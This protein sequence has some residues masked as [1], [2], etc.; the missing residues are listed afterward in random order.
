MEYLVERSSMTRA[1]GVGEPVEGEVGATDRNQ[2][3]EEPECPDKEFQGDP[4]EG[5]TH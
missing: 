5:G 4:G 3:V 2:T 1:E